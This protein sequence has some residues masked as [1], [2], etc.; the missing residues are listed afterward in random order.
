MHLYLAPACSAYQEEEEEDKYQVFSVGVS[1]HS[2]PSV[3]SLF[4]PLC[5]IV[6]AQWLSS[7]TCVC[8]SD[9]LPVCLARLSFGSSTRRF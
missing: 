5:L 4:V 7:Y 8:H 3:R 9:G 1:L 2:Q 6:H